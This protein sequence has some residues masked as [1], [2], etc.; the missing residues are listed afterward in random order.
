M[1]ARASTVDQ[2]SLTRAADAMNTG[3]APPSAIRR[4]HSCFRSNP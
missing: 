1:P 4:A 2:I 3:S